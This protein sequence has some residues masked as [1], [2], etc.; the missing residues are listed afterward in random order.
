MS[1][2]ENFQIR[3]VFNQETLHS[4]G[5]R[6]KKA[7]PEGNLAK[8]KKIALNQLTALTYS[9][10]KSQIVTALESFLP[11]DFLKAAHI[12]INALPPP[13][14]DHSISESMDRFIVVPMA[15]YIA[16][17]GLDNPEIS[18]Q[19]LKSMTQC[20]TAEWAIRPFLIHH[21]EMTMKTLHAWTKD[22]NEH[23]RRLV[24]EGSR[25]YLPWGKKLAF[26]ADNPTITLPLLAKMKT[27]SSEYVRRSIA[28]HLNDLSKNHPDLIIQELKKWQLESPSQE[29]TKM[30]K[31]ALRTTIKNGHP[32]A[33][34]MIGFKHGVKVK[35]TDI[36]FSSEI[37]FGSD[38]LF[39]ITLLSNEK[40]Q[41]P[42]HLDFI[43]H[44]QKN[45]GKTQPKVFKLKS[46][47]I[48]PGETIS[49]RKK[50]SFRPITTRKYYPGTHFLQILIN[51]KKTKKQPF[52]LLAP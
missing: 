6:L 41:V 33:L 21:R 47:I 28:N 27:D 17:Y 3:D 7:Y 51:G 50:I 10:R 14:E 35:V 43:I 32:E 29:M 39:T 18:L 8:F 19:I 31:H 26:V 38:L 49:V 37:P 25:P 2:K 11:P 4:L 5:N 24:S 34:D 42:I 13:Y 23:V 1:K 40:M 46:L 16:I 44:Y 9:G 30:I 20:F 45:S 48:K 22:N 36:D 15:E 52:K 12:L